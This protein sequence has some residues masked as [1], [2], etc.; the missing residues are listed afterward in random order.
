MHDPLF[1]K[2]G[3]GGSAT[4]L[5][6]SLQDGCVSATHLASLFGMEP[7][8]MRIGQI[9]VSADRSGMISN[10][11]T[12]LAEFP[13]KGTREDPIPLGGTKKDNI[14]TLRAQHSSLLAAQQASYQADIKRAAQ[15]AADRAA[16]QAQATLKRHMDELIEQMSVGH[17]KAH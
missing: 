9:G 1:F 11:P 14:E 12:L 2:Y 10:M 17:V 15:E 5:G 7:D 3:E 6:V 16:E 13:G 4:V 8:S